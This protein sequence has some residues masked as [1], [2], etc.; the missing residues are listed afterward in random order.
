MGHNPVPTQNAASQYPKPGAPVEVPGSKP[1]SPVEA[2]S[3]P[4]TE[5]RLQHERFELES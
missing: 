5:S 3:E 4:R 2:P 1:R